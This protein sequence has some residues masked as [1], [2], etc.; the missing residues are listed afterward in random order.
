MKMVNTCLGAVASAVVSL[1]AT[2]HAATITGVTAQQRYPWNGKVD[3]SYTVTGDIAAEA[4]QKAVLTS[5][6]VT[7]TDRIANMTYTATQLSGDTALTAGEHSLVW[8]M[9]ADG[10]SFKSSN[11]VFKV[12]CATTPATYCVIDLSAGANATD[13][14]VTYLAEPPSGGF[15]VDE[16]KTTKLVLRRIEPGSFLMS[17]QYNVTL[18]RPFFCGVFEVTQKQYELVMGTNPSSYAGDKR[19]VEMVSYNMIRGATNGALWPASSNVD[20]DSFIGKLRSRTGLDFD[21]PTEAQWEYACRAGTT[22]DYNNGG[23][24]ENDLKQLGRYSGNQTDGKGGYS[25]TTTVGSY[26]ANAWELY[27]MH[28]NVIEWTL[29]WYRNDYL[30]GN[31]TNPVGPPDGTGSRRVRRGGSFG[32]NASDCASSHRGGTVYTGASAAIGFRLA[33]TLSGE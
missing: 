6:K 10:L 31:V 29:D 11:V 12:S 20:G 32:N 28:G 26:V 18:T 24:T 4:K 30:S 16:Y 15:N 7:A 21:L 25:E 17:G 19:P 22:S 23:N 2:A 13:Y 3:I 33:R 27:D 14:P 8:D 9:D 1:A 5:L